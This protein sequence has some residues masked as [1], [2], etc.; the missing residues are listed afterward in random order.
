MATR[1]PEQK[2]TIPPPGNLPKGFHMSNVWLD[3]DGRR[4]EGADEVPINSQTLR[5]AG[6]LFLCTQAGNGCQVGEWVI[7]RGD[8]TAIKP[9]KPYCPDHGV[10]VQRE[11]LDDRDPNAVAGARRRMGDRVA[12][13]LRRRR[14][15]VVEATT[16]R[17]LAAQQAA[18]DAGKRTAADYAAHAPT[19]AVAAVAITAAASAAEAGPPLE[20]AAAACAFAV[21]GGVLAYAM[22][23]AFSRERARQRGARVTGGSRALAAAKRDGHA[24]AAGVAATGLWTAADTALVAAGHGQGT[25]L[26][27]LMLGVAVLTAWFIGRGH[28][29]GLSERRR[30]LRRLAAERARQAA[31]A[32]EQEVKVAEAAVDPEPPPAPFDENNALQVGERMARQWEEISRHSDIG[33]RFAVMP[34]TRILPELTRAVMA[35]NPEGGQ[36]RIGWEFMIQGEPGVLVPAPGLASPLINARVWL[37]AMLGRDPMSTAL[38]ER[39]DNDINRAVL[40]VTDGAPLGEPVPYLGRAGIQVLS[41]G[42]ILGHDGRDIKGKDTF[43]PLYIPGQTFGGAVLGRSGGGKA[44]KLDTPIPTPAGWTTMGAL[45]AGDQVFDETG[46]PCT[47]V[48][49]F[50]VL[51]GQTCYEVVFSDGSVITADAGHLWQTSTMS[52]RRQAGSPARGKTVHP[53]A[54]V[55]RLNA[56]VR[57]VLDEP[58]RPMICSE[59]VGAVGAVFG[60]TVENAA[61]TLPVIGSVLVGTGG[62]RARQFSSHVLCSAVAERAN[63]IK[64]SHRV[65]VFDDKP[66]TTQQILDTLHRPHGHTNHA[67]VVA[68]PLQYEKKELPFPAYSLGAWL[69][70]GDSARNY[71]TCADQEIL[72]RMAVEGVLCD[73]ASGNKYRYRMGLAGDRTRGSV[74]KMLRQVGV[75]HNKHIPRVYLEA[76]EEQRWALLAGLLDTDGYC[77]KSGKVQFSNTKERL[78]RDVLELVLGLGFKATLTSKPCKGRRPDSSV[79]YSV[80]FTPDVPVF[81]LTRKAAR[82]RINNTRGTTKQ[83]YIVDVRP[84][85]ST[86]VRCIMVDSPSHLFLAGRECIPTHNSQARRVRILNNLY[87]GIYT[88]LYDPKNFVDYS[89]FAGIIP[90]GCTVEHRDVILRSLWAEMVRRQQML[91]QLVGTDRF[92]RTRPIEGAWKVGRDGAPLLSIWDE[93]HL[94]S[95][96]ADY[97]ARITTLCRL[98]RATASGVEVATQGGGLA[99]LGDSVLRMLLNQTG[100]EVYRMSKSQ[101]KLGGYEGDFDPQDLPSIPGMVLKVYGEGGQPIPQRSAFVTRE[102]E[103]GSVYDHLY[104]PDGSQILFLPQM[105]PETIE[106]FEREGLMDL[107]RMGQGPGGLARLQAGDG[108]STLPPPGALNQPGQAPAGGKPIEA[109]DMILAI[110]A[111]DHIAT[112]QQIDQHPMWLQDPNRKGLPDPS[113]ISKPTAKMVRE[114]LLVDP[115]RPDVWRELTPRGRQVAEKALMAFE[116]LVGRKDGPAEPA[117]G[118]ET[119]ERIEHRVLQEHEEQQLARQLAAEMEAP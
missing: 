100:L 63:K 115:Q 50:P 76:G 118:A 108:D 19:L 11:Q 87:A 5:P 21:A 80:T 97:V 33:N 64:N 112:R 8:G 113:T 62:S 119:P 44:L 32:A 58:D 114:G 92:G 36:R 35:P 53:A 74:I 72:D 84:V 90:M 18:M 85:P 109:R 95:K 78:A 10:P 24:V 17:L 37:A 20:V 102:D 4:V 15:V 105:A 59:L 2:R 31:A 73:K 7:D 93:F 103:D 6:V 106:V 77:A 13:A 48:Q 101:A 51:Y 99:D 55:A 117:G 23:Y 71:F 68:G 1:A 75:L 29:E 66:V 107:L 69:G 46:A 60:C 28:W 30:E 110:L 16:A 12:A 49:A 54:D 38:V 86:P 111:K 25:V 98:Q 56:F 94:E 116:V 45:K 41:N 34:R 83:R 9:K 26:G 22:A 27:T 57:R 91:S 96:D 89:E 70:D 39:P 67:V 43:M 104:A 42:T 52:G 88:T 47:V 14:L 81:R 82:Q 3:P 61:K 79:A 65:E 40:L